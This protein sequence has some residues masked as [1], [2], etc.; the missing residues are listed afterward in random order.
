M[1]QIDIG[2]LPL[3]LTPLQDQSSGGH[4]AFEE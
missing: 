3:M 2:C 1:L 4:A